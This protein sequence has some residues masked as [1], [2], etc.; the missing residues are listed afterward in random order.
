MKLII[1]DLD[2]TLADFLS[3]HEEATRRLFKQFFDVD[4]RL[5]EIDFAGKSLIE[6]FSELARLKDIPE[7]IFRRR[8]NQL[9]ESL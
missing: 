3:V 5:T 6:N 9:L 4:A 7:D 2:Q 1:F 8:I